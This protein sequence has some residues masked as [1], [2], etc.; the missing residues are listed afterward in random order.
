M[1]QEYL[2]LINLFN[3]ERVE[4]VMLGGHAVIG[5]GSSAGYARPG[6]PSR[7]DKGVSRFFS[8]ST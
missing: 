1:E 3:E 8:K 4:Y 5:Y 2:S 7:R 6:E